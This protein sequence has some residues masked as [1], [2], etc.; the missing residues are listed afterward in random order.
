MTPPPPMNV[1]TLWHD[2]LN[3]GNIMISNDNINPHIV[4]ILDWQ[5]ASIGS[6]YLQFCEPHFFGRLEEYESLYRPDDVKNHSDTEYKLGAKLA[7]EVDELRPLYLESIIKRHPYIAEARSIPYANLQKLLM[8]ISAT[9]WTM[10]DMVI[11]L[12]NN[13][14]RLWYEWESYGFGS[15]RPFFLVSR[16]EADVHF[17]E[18]EWAEKQD[19]FKQKIMRI[20]G[21]S[22]I[23]EV[24]P[25]EYQDGK[26]LFEDIKQQLFEVLNSQWDAQAVS[27]KKVNWEKHWPFRYSGLGL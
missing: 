20:V 8:L 27:K 24:E 13:L 11:S 16:E 3:F 5:N 1:G 7:L 12:R 14:F 18:Y 6:L 25:D 2:D 10:E 17:D 21:M 9:T 4:S 22:Y 23:G 19:H 15:R 26:L